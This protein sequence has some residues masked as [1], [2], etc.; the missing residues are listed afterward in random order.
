MRTVRLLMV[1]AG[2]A[3]TGCAA[4]QSEVT[5]RSGIGAEVDLDAVRP[6]S[7]VTYR[8]SLTSDQSPVPAVMSLTSRKRSGNRYTYNGQLVLTLPEAEKL[9]DIA[10][11]ISEALGKTTVRAKGNQLFVPVGLTADNRFRSSR[12]NI[13]ADVTRYAPHDCFAVLGTCRYQAIDR[14]GNVAA[15]LTETTEQDGVWRSKTVLDPKAQNKG[16]AAETRRAVYSI[17]KNAVLIDMVVTR[18]A[19]PRR[20]QF[21]IRRQ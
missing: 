18:G 11:V 1:L 21:A 5:I 3:L 14:G 4:P 15:L 8:F 16:L 7:G 10:A 6:P 17:D 2:F 9:E 20:S 12:S 13:T 19:G